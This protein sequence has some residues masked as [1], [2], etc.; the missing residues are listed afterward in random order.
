M[1]TYTVR[2]TDVAPALTG[3]WDGPI[4][5]AAETLDIGEFCADSSAHRPV[6]RARL[7]YDEAKVYGIF[8]VQDRYVRCVHT[9]FQDNVCRDSCVEF[10]VTPDLSQGY[11]NFEFNCGGTLLCF[12]VQDATRTD[13]GFRKFAPLTPEEARE[14]QIYHSLPAVV[15]PEIADETDWTLEFAVPLDLFAAHFRLTGPARCHSWRA[16]LYKC[17]DATSHPH[18][19]SWSPLTEKNFH[20][21]ACF[22]AL[23]FAE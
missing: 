7:L 18:W 6:T 1:V 13:A 12:H 5:R 17:G 23:H 2:R 9:E 4:W 20:L 14:V 21:P 15:E 10:F 19:A 11:L 8:H 22:G 16:N 3:D